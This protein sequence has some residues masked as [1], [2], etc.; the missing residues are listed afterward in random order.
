MVATAPL[1][2]A[3]ALVIDLTRDA[4]APP[5][6]RLRFLTLRLLTFAA[7]YLTCEMAGVLLAFWIWLRHGPW[8]GAP[9]S[10]FLQ[11]NFRL[12]CVWGSTL[13]AIGRRLYRLR[14][15]VE[16][17]QLASPGPILLYVRHSSLADT[18]LAVQLVAAPFGMRLRYVLK[19]PL[20]FDPCLD[21][22]GLRLP[23]R[24]SQKGTSRSSDEIAAVADLAN[25][26][27]SDEGVLIY[28]EG[29]RFTDVKRQQLLERLAQRGDE[30]QLE[31]AQ[32]LR[33]VLPPVAGGPAALLRRNRQLATPADLVICA[34]CGLEES[35]TAADLW[36]GKLLDQ[37]VA[38]RFWRI[39]AAELPREGQ[40][41]Q[42]WLYQHWHRVDEFVAQHK[43][44]SVREPAAEVG[45]LLT[46]PPHDEP[47]TVTRPRS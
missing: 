8:T 43:P 29:T 46:P 31:R 4:A 36:H 33:F 13:F 26:L 27:S 39:P 42:E 24:F 19:R 45:H 1:T 12:Q 37:E 22:V 15:N 47:S 41:E 14:L 38:V 20:L 23:N 10:R 40:D 35:P 32:R 25:G 16:G 28:P 9:Q 18:V 11:H 21:I 30:Q 6:R 44:A 7:A 5:P 2:V 3:V 17:Q 34:H